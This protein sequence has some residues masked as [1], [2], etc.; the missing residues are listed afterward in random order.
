MTLPP[1]RRKKGLEAP[2]VSTAGNVTNRA[3]AVR[4]DCDNTM[5]I[6]DDGDTK[7][8]DLCA[9]VD[10]C[11][12][13]GGP[14][15]HH[16]DLNTTVCV[17]TPGSYSCQ[18]NVGYTHLNRFECADVDECSLSDKNFPCHTHATCTNSP[19]GFSC[20]CRDGYEGDGLTCRREYEQ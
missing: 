15:G 3:V 19:G 10:E 2:L 14:N 5:T 1:L 11:T 4:H 8:G 13:V 12:S 7:T 6:C 20:K 18:C 17:N 9:D 16:C